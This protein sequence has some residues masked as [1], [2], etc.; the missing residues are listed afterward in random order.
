MLDMTEG[1]SS[2]QFV[3]EFSIPIPSDEGSLELTK[4]EM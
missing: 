1:G 4:S 2:I 3:E